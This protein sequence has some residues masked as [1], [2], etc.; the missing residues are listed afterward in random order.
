MKRFFITLFFT[1]LVSLPLSINAQS[2]N[3]THASHATAAGK[4]QIQ[5]GQ[6]Y[7]RMETP[8]KVSTGDKI[9]VRE[10][11]WYGCPH[12][13]QLEPTII[14][15][16]K[17]K[18]ENAEFIPMP[19]VFSQRW[20]FHAKVYYT[21]KAL[22][23]EE[24]AHPMVFESIHSKRKP[25]NNTKQLTK[26]LKANFD[27]DASKVESAYNSF[28]VDSNMRSANAY[29]VKSGA[30]GVPTIIVDGKFRTSVQAA[31][32]NN[33]LFAVVDQLVALAQSER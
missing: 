3:N 24:K 30:N 13:N 5:E 7:I 9:E 29:S 11:F 19:A 22:G 23:I 16:L 28:T 26:F 1:A 10:M 20:I 25:I 27:I 17:T 4:A 15:W 31:G 2:Q 6:H 32:G 14:N 33:Q 8:L 12:C 21:L 18:P